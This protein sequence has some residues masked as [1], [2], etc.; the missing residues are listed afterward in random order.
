M[1]RGPTFYNLKYYTRADKI[2][3]KK[4]HYRRYLRYFLRVKLGADKIGKF[5]NT[6]KMLV[7]GNELFGPIKG[8]V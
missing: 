5:V 2:V 7:L 8:T 3:L 1:K 4:P 6:T